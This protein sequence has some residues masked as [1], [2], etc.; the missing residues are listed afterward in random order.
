MDY[1]YNIEELLPL[2]NTRKDILLRNLIKN[3]TENTHYIITKLDYKKNGRPKINY[4]LTEKAFELLKNS[5]NFRNRYIVNIADNITCTNNIAMCIENQTIGFIVN[6]FDGII[7]TIRQFK[8]GIYK[9]DLYFP[10]HNLVV[11]N[12]ENGHKDRDPD[13]EKQRQ[14]FILSE[15]KIILRYNP[16]KCNFDLSLVLREI[17]R[18]LYNKKSEISLILL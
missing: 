1:K 2:L 5:F 16:N 6:S 10:D 14:D 13:K 15:G 7:E 17:N 3:Y 8:I 9:V 18:I 4:M 11:E 12:D